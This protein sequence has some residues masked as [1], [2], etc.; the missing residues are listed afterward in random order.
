MKSVK[1]QRKAS[2]DYQVPKQATNVSTHRLVK[3]ST[4][5]V[6]DPLRIADFKQ[7]HKVGEGSYSSVK[8]FVKDGHQY[9]CKIFRKPLAP[10]ILE[11]VK[12]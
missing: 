3:S 11:N 6:H 5:L 12:S 8:I 10:Q 1:K 7:L 4:G 2:I 9:A